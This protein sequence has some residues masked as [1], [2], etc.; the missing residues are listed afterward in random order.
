MYMLVHKNKRNYMGNIFNIRIE[1]E[2][3]PT[4]PGRAHSS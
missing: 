4:M 3:G 2:D 1:K